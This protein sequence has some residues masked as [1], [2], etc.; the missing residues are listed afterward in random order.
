[1]YVTNSSCTLFF[2]VVSIP[3]KLQN[4]H[5]SLKIFFNILRAYLT[6]IIHIEMC[7][8]LVALPNNVVNVGYLPYLSIE[9]FGYVAD[10]LAV[11][12]R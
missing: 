7:G 5:D 10:E 2:L 4:I 3:L 8:S 9:L 6:E 12:T 1:M 11:T